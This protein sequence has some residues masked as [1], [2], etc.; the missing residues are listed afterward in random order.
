MHE[1][2][3]ESDTSLEL[4]EIPANSH[5]SNSSHH[6]PSFVDV[7][8]YRDPLHVM[9]EYIAEVSISVEPS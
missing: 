7:S 6:F 5:V 4:I 3:P 1:P 8:K 9:L 2:E